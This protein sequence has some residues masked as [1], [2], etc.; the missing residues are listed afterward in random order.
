MDIQIIFEIENNREKS[1]AVA[2]GK[3]LIEPF[4]HPGTDRFE[5]LEFQ[6]GTDQ[7]K[8]GGKEDGK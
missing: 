5:G 8:E 4:C 3:A 7:Q 2:V 1:I 6:L